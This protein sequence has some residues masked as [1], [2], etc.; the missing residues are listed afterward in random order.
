MNTWVARLR[1]AMLIVV[2]FVVHRE[3]MQGVS[4]F[5]I[6]AAQ[7]YGSAA[8]LDYFL[9]R[10]AFHFVKGNLCDDMED[11]GYISIAANFLGWVSYY[12]SIDTTYYLVFMKSHSVIQAIRLLLVDG[13][14]VAISMR[15]F[16]LR[17][18]FAGRT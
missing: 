17:R 16:V 10:C 7:Y 4:Q 1:Y 12:F 9:V 3:A 8:L 14:D 5:E 15:G 6:G 11:L 18:P 13:N 2:A